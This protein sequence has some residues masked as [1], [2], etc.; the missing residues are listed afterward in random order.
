MQAPDSSHVSSVVQSIP[1]L[2]PSPFS[3][4]TGGKASEPSSQ[5]PGTKQSSVASSPG[6]V[7]GKPATQPWPIAH[8]SAPLQNRPSVQDPWFG[9]PS[10][11]PPPVQASFSV[12]PMPSSHPLPVSAG[13]SVKLCVASSQG[14]GTRQSPGSAS[15]PVGASPARQPTTVLQL[16]TPLQ[17]SWSSQRESSAA[18]AQAPSASQTSAVVQAIP[19]SQLSPAPRFT[20]GKLWVSSSHSP[21]TTQSVGLGSFPLTG[22]P[23]T[24]PSAPASMLSGW[25]VSSPLQYLLSSHSESSVH[26]G[27]SSSPLGM[28]SSCT[29]GLSVPFV[30]S[31]ARASEDAS[32]SGVESSVSP[33]QLARSARPRA[34]VIVIRFK[35]SSP[36]WCF[37]RRRLRS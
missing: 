31:W 23:A 20:V 1:S 17:N 37:K 12:H 34:A 7:G 15:V 25:Q 35:R 6:A 19:S 13:M 29:S 21:S 16:S 27:T 28:S 11:V 22:S 9:A 18:P 14:P 36:F 4:G 8:S 5:G 30:V 33:P 26:S 2:H 24:Q 32:P 3:A 10:Q